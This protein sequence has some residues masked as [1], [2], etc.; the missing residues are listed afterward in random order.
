MEML[1]KAHLF[2][3]MLLCD[4]NLADKLWC[5]SY[6]RKDYLQVRFFYSYYRHL[7]CFKLICINSSGDPILLGKVK[8]YFFLY[9]IK[10]AR[11]CHSTLS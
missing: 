9:P 11:Y 4:F 7:V 2:Y 5:M 1:L 6:K 3:V 8:N 10:R